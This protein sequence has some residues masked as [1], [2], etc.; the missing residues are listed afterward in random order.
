MDLNNV[1]IATHVVLFGQDKWIMRNLEN[2]YRHVDKIYVAYSDEPWTYN[3]HAR[4]KFK[5]SFDLNV[6]RNSEYNDKV[7]IIEGRWN[8]EEEQRNSCVDAAIKDG[9]DFLVI[10]DADEFYFHDQFA[11]ALLIL[12]E[13]PDWD[14]YRVGWYC[15]WKNFN[16]ILLDSAGNKITGFPEFAINLKRGVRFERKRRPN[17]S[18]NPFDISVDDAIC[19][20]GS[21]VLSDK[22]V[23]EKINT[24]GHA[25]EF[26]GDNWYKTKWLKW[27]PEMNNLHMI[28]PHAWSKAEKFDGVL[29]IVINDLR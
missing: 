4:G 3:I 22:E 27:T 8:T 12:R 5:N 21:Y 28:A 13:N 25:A 10:H 2:A 6:I 1:K 17:K 14:F 16:Y 24:W 11:K 9:M 20:H 23:Y 26:D 19:Y 7:T 18:N 29:P 15:F